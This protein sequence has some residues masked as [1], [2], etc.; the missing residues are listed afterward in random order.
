MPIPALPLYEL[1]WHVAREIGQQTVAENCYIYIYIFN[2]VFLELTWNL[3]NVVI[4]KKNQK[5]DEPWTMHEIK[6]ITKLNFQQDT[7]LKFTIQIVSLAD[8]VPTWS[9]IYCSCL[10]VFYVREYIEYFE[11]T[12]VEHTAQSH[13]YLLLPLLSFLFFPIL[14][15]C[16]TLYHQ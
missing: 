11:F 14:L 1:Y 6:F 8:Y 13:I 2:F 16:C 5:W 10:T 3:F 4:E 9:F 7:L 15:W 12:S